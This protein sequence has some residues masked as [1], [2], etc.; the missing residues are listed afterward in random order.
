MELNLIHMK[1]DEDAPLIIDGWPFSLL[2]LEFAYVAI[3]RD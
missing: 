1:C 3:G 2:Q